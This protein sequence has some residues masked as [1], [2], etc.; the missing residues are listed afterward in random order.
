MTHEY[1]GHYGAKHAP[2]T[3]LDPTL[4]KRVREKTTVGHL[5]CASAFAIVEE[6]GASP[7]E[8]GRAA[9]LL[10]IKISKCQLGLFGHVKEKRSI[11]E[12]AGKVSGELEQALREGVVKGRL[13]CRKAWDIAGRFGIS[14]MEVTSACESLNIRLGLCQLGTF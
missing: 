9:D 2:D 6:A 8:I 5:A 7:I 3:P 14:K 4:A 10:E 11:V 13:S 12:P 1:E